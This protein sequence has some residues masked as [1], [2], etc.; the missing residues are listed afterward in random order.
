MPPIQFDTCRLEHG[1]QLQIA[2]MD[3]FLQHD[4]DIASL[5][6]ILS[7]F[8]RVLKED[9]RLDICFMQILSAY[10]AIA[11]SSIQTSQIWT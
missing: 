9:L 10:Y 1:L 8:L 2:A 4:L 5:G 3:Q 6:Q 11:S 7:Y